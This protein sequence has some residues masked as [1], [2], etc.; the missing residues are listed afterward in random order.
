[1]IYKTSKGTKIGVTAATAYYRPLYKL[2]GWELSEPLSELENQIAELQKQADIIIVLSHL[3]MHDDQ[4]IAE[5]NP[6]VD[7]I[8]GG[9]THHVFMNGKKVN[10]TTLCAAGR[11]GEYIG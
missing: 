6:R 2:L 5:N 7:L 1:Q 3:G 11:Y 8:L 10:H 4:K 9:H